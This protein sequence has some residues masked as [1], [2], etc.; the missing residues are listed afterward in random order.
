MMNKTKIILATN[1]ST[2]QIT[3]LIIGTIVVIGTLIYLL[4]TWY[5]K[6]RKIEKKNRMMTMNLVIKYRPFLEYLNYQ[7]TKNE[8]FNIYLVKINNLTALE[9]RFNDNI[10]R[11]YLTRIAKELS[12]YLPFGGKIA[13]TNI[14]D[15]FIIYYPKTNEDEYEVGERF[16]AL[17]N[18][19]FT[20]GGL[21]IVKTNS[22]A[23]VDD[24]DYNNKNLTDTLVT[25]TRQL[26]AVTK[27][28][29]NINNGSSE[30][31]NLITR[32]NDDIYNVNSFEVIKNNDNR[33]KEIYNEIII[34]NNKIKTYL[35]K[36]PTI[37]QAWINLNIIENLINIL[38]DNNLF[39]NFSLPILLNVLE[40][41]L[42]VETLEHL[43]IGNGYLM[44]QVILSIKITNVTN[45]E[46]VIKNLL[47]LSNLG[48][49]LSIELPNLN[50]E[51]YSF[52][53]KYNINRLEIDDNLM[54]DSQISELLYF[55]KVNNL[56]IIYKTNKKEQDMSELN[57][58]HLTVKNIELKITNNKKKR[59]RK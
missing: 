17:A 33:Y 46:K 42:F 38:N 58:T 40:K 49:K 3:L 7:S 34:N 4:I 24:L 54:N 41:D 20:I 21:N 5:L 19:S 22:V 47:L 23:I 43:I 56:E 59:G 12:V 8:S 44:E 1:M 39:L 18:K 27:Y 48:V 30:Y 25:S 14:R 2:I 26:G 36:V 13:Q 55:A 45:E 52:I 37:D 11:A 53:Q 6:S 15:T 9:Q 31:F 50:Q 28:D 16:K 32:L 35:E 10:V 57:V 29:E 51:N